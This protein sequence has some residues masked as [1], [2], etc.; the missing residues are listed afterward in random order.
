MRSANNV[1]H[2]ERIL[3]ESSEGRWLTRHSET[4]YLRPSMAMREIAFLVGPKPA[5]ESLGT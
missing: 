5:S 3:A 4:P 2:C 1:L